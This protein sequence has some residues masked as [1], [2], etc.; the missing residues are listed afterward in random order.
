MSTGSTLWAHALIWIPTRN[1]FLPSLLPQVP[2]EDLAWS[3][4]H[5]PVERPFRLNLEAPGRQGK[6]G[7]PGTLSG[8]ITLPSVRSCR[9]C[10]GLWRTM[11]QPES[12]ARYRHH[13]KFEKPESFVLEDGLDL[14]INLY[15]TTQPPS[16]ART[17]ET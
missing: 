6:P 7:D 13:Q 9:T 16:G 14:S 8:H 1:D 5:H 2:L 4:G 11:R 17:S 10:R 12:P 3:F 15:G